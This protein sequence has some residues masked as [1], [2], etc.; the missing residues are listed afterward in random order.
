MSFVTATIQ[1]TILSIISNILA[2]TIRSYRSGAPFNIDPTSLFNFALFA[3][4]STPP[5]YLWQEL[6]EHWFPTYAS[7]LPPKK[8]E[9]PPSAP[10]KKLSKR[11]IIQKILVDQAICGPLNTLAFL[12]FMK[13]VAVSAD[14]APAADILRA[15][16]ADFPALQIA[17]FKLW[18]LVAVVSFTLVPVERRV[19][20]G[21][22]VALGWNVYLGLAMG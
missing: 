12:A 11:N 4:L 22:L 10:S 3:F 19:L 21:S 15:V 1:A 16:I 14:R 2:Q 9:K 7:T 6:L 18:P 5:N 20:F 8:S 17:S 13:G